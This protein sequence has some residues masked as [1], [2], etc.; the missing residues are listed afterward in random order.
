MNVREA[1]CI[2]FG[3]KSGDSLEEYFAAWQWLYDHEVEL[4]ESDINFLDKLICDGSVIPKE[5]YFKTI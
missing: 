4:K 2:A 1:K 5:D 3:S